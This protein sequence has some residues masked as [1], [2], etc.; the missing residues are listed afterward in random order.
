MPRKR[1]RAKTVYDSIL[2]I[3]LFGLAALGWLQLL[4][5]YP[6]YFFI[7]IIITA[8]ILFRVI[9]LTRKHVKLEEYNAELNVLFTWA[10]FLSEILRLT[11]VINNKILLVGVLLVFI[12]IG[13]V[14]SIMYLIAK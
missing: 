10:F 12:P 6:E 4:D 13:A 7:S 9:Y 14:M 1:V 2:P 11:H 3:L 5:T 8:F